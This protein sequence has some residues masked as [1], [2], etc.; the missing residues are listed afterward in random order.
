MAQEQ[1]QPKKSSEEVD[2]TAEIYEPEA[3]EAPAPVD[4]APEPVAV[5]AV[6]AAP[7]VSAPAPRRRA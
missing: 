7:V 2:E 4:S 3:G 1:K 6:V 5:S